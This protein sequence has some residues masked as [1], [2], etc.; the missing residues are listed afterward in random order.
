MAIRTG[1]PSAACRVKRAR[2]KERG[3][4]VQENEGNCGTMFT[5]P[6][7][8][9]GEVGEGNSD[10]P[11]RDNCQ[12]AAQQC[13]QHGFLEVL[14]E[15]GRGRA[16]S[17]AIYVSTSVQRGR[18]DIDRREEGFSCDYTD[19]RPASDEVRIPDGCPHQWEM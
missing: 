5:D 4:G 9:S 3:E 13:R 14:G 11:L 2:G 19:T 10:D 6:A 8:R 18:R 16:R 1:V 15:A 7:T 17:G 12:S